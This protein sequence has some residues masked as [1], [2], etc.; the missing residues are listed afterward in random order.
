[1]PIVP[2][3]LGRPASVWISAMARGATRPARKP[4]EPGRYAIPAQ[5]V[6][7]LART[8]RAVPAGR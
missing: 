4:G 7:G 6:E 2:Y 8:G 1:M 5:P 3:F